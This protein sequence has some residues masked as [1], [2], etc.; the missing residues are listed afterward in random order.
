MLKNSCLNAVVSI[1]NLPGRVFDYDTAHNLDRFG[2]PKILDAPSYLKACLIRAA[3][4]MFKDPESQCAILQE[5]ARDSN[6]LNLMFVDARRPV[7]LSTKPDG[8]D[9]QAFCYYAA[10]AKAN[11]P[12]HNFD[13]RL[14]VSLQ[15]QAY[16]MVRSNGLPW[17][18]IIRKRLHMWHEHVSDI[19]DW[20][21][22]SGAS[23]SS[24]SSDSSGSTSSHDSC[25]DFIIP[26]ISIAIVDKAAALA[27]DMSEGTRLCYVKSLVNGWTT[28]R[29]CHERRVHTCVF[30]CLNSMDDTRHY[31]R[32][33]QPLWSIVLSV[34]NFT[35]EEATP[36]FN[37]DVP[38]ILSLYNP[39]KRKIKAVVLAY[40]I[41]NYFRHEGK[42]HA[43]TLRRNRD[44]DALH[45][46]LFDVACALH[47]HHF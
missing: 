15:K 1:M 41:Y 35:T 23:S 43:T 30:G 12:L 42:D 27:K 2:G 46:L 14:K 33:C 31:F 10:R 47:R 24:S 11:F 36:F 28:S 40:R 9:A 5:G 34:L 39:T 22:S 29:R 18:S 13:E 19:E 26:V 37:G 4:K 7:H 25:P 44:M 38:S 21:S 45:S 6:A 20:S 3:H 17:T 16:N 8:W 32:K